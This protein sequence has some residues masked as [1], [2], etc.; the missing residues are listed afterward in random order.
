MM[1]MMMT[2]DDEYK[3]DNNEN[4]TTADIKTTVIITTTINDNDGNNDNNKFPRLN[5]KS[6]NRERRGNSQSKNASHTSIYHFTE[7][8]FQERLIR[9]MIT[10]LLYFTD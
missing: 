2:N 4:T 7:N 8:V 5:L 9:L 10:V 3:G 6:H 1:I